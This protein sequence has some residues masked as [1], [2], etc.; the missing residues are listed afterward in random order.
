MTLSFKAAVLHAPKTPMRFETIAA[1]KL[2]PGDVLVKM[3]AAGLCHTDLEVIEGSLRYPMPIVLGHEA[4][5]V[6][7]EVGPQAKGV[8]VATM[9][10]CRGTRIA[11]IASTATAICRSS[12][13]PTLPRARKR[14]PSMAK[15]ASGERMAATSSS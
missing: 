13:R 12:A 3:R 11:G 14:L 15:A 7:E 6:V 8:A 2:K 4:A 10:F 1:G 9:S 5:G